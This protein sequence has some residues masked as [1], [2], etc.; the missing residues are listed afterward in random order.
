M[1]CTWPKCKQNASICLKSHK[2]CGHHARLVE[3]YGGPSH[4][5]IEV[6][7]ERLASQLEMEVKGN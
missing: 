3:D 5:C 1:K 4:E 2:L 7:V 6:V